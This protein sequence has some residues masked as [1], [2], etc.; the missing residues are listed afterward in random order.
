MKRSLLIAVAL[1]LC[2]G[3]SA[4]WQGVKE[5]TSK[6]TDWTKDKVNEGATT[7]KQKTE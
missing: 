5:D 4:T 1:I 3:C 2:T 7:V 6:A